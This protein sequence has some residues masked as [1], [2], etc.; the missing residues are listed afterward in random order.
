M[1]TYGTMRMED[2][3][4]VVDAA[5]H[6]ML[7]LKRVFDKVEKHAT[8]ARFAPTPENCRELEWFAQRYPF[9]VDPGIAE[10]IAGKAG[11]HRETIKSLSDLVDPN[12]V[13]PT[14]PMAMPARNYQTVGTQIYLKQGFQLNCDDLGLGKTCS[15]ICSLTDPQTLPA[16]ITTHPAL[17]RQWWEEIIKF[18]PGLR[19]HVLH[20]GT[21]YELPKIAGRGPDVLLTSYHK[22]ADWSAVMQA[23]GRS[24]VFDE[25]QELRRQE[26]EKYKAAKA[27]S[28]EMGFRLGLTA[29]PV[30]NYGDEMWSVCDVLKDGV[31]GTLEE[32]Y[33]EWCSSRG[34]GRWMVNDPIALGSYLR[35]HFV[36][37]RR[38]RADVGRELPQVIRVPHAI[39][40]DASV[41]KTIEGRAA[42]LASILLDR[43]ER[44]VGEKMQA[45]GELD[46]IVRQATGLA[47]APYVASFVEMLV[48]DGRKVVLAG[49]HHAVYAVWREHLKK[50][51]IR[52]VQYTGE[53][54]PKEKHRSVACFRS[55]DPADPDFP[56]ADVFIISLRAGVGLNGLQEISNLMVIGELDWSP[57][58]HEQL[59]GRLQRDGQI[60]QVTVYFLHSQYG[61]DPTMV[62]VL[63]LKTEQV[64]GIRNPERPI[65]AKLQRGEDGIRMIAE[66]YLKKGGR[67]LVGAS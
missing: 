67:V 48:A 59:I 52:V 2:G 35:E 34:N 44:K 16:I 22:L 8:I 60:G 32:F 64:E 7:R 41:F 43:A 36:M 6:V 53:E 63:G 40:S 39:D 33:R 61:A 65:V 24:I 29:T 12:Y 37:I 30:Y 38:T 54:S 27:I 47:K 4:L 1:V 18:M 46:R 21:P 49:W 50:A 62:E 20:Q 66:R 56:A 45:G 5:P 15:A 26:S 11:E 25:I 17:Q 51:G 57:G 42:E 9:D 31:L 14:L 28:R 3:R 55:T 23:Y 19:V 13:A 10:L 58:A